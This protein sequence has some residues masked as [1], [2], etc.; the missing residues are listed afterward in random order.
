[1]RGLRECIEGLIERS[2]T[3]ILLCLRV[4]IVAPRIDFVSAS[5]EQ[6]RGEERCDGAQ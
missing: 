3:E 5:A 4:I 1:M 6:G 2:T